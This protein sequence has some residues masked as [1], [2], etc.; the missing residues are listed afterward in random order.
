MRRK[1]WS[2]SDRGPIAGD[3]LREAARVTPR[4]GSIRARAVTSLTSIERFFVPDQL[5]PDGTVDER[6]VRRQQ[7]RVVGVVAV[8]SFVVFVPSMPVVGVPA[9]LWPSF[10]AGVVATG[11]IIAGSLLVVPAGT[12]AGLLAAAACAVALFGF[13]RLIG[14]YYHEL[15]LL[16]AFV[17]A[18]HVMVKGWGA[19]L[20]MAL[21]GAFLVPLMG[22]ASHVSNLTDNVYAFMYLLA[23]AATL[24]VHKRLQDRGT[25]AVG[26]SAARY[27]ELVERVPAIV[28]EADFALP[29]LWRYVSPRAEALLGFPAEAWT[30]AP[31][32][33]WNRVH[34]DDRNLLMAEGSESWQPAGQLST[35][36]YR[37]IGRDG[38]VRWVRDEATVVPSRDGLAAYRSGLLIDITEQKDLEA[39]LRQAQRMEAVGQLAGGIAHDF[40]NVL[41]A[42]KGYGELVR[43]DFAPDARG[44][45][46]LEEMLKAADR[47]ADL[48]RQLLAFSRKQILQPKV[49][50]PATVIEEIAPM[51]RRLIGEHIELVTQHMVRDAS[52]LVDQSQ[53]EQV[54][55]NLSVNA[56]DAMPDGGRLE[57]RTDVVVRNSDSV[58][59]GG[60][61]TPGS[62]LRIRVV[63]SGHGMDPATRARI[64]E[65]FFTTKDVGR[66]TGMGLATVYGIVR[67]SGGHIACMSEPG[68]GATFE[69]DLPLV[70]PSAPYPAPDL[71]M[72][73]PLGRETILL[74]EDDSAV[75]S[76]ARRVLASLGYTVFEASSGAEAMEL[77]EASEARLDLLVTDVRM[78]Q[79]QGPDLA[80]RLRAVRPGLAV[81]LMSGFPGDQHMGAPGTTVEIPLLPKP[82]DAETLGRAVRSALDAPH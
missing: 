20:V 33:W 52:V 36:E 37:M 11:F 70:D 15:P 57:I 17:V 82:F 50:R 80:R 44:R 72:P 18:G 8:A 81:L 45:E 67:Q 10:V 58:E 14:D 21:C 78:P 69:L 73:P 42:I 30:N 49:I 65:P 74:V 1:G 6:A 62:S 22:A 46:D 71:E 9:H 24:W 40:N 23:I 2:V 27:R 68:H 29:G 31:G 63:D 59:A 64:F 39:R 47:A 19:A 66:G 38:G 3:G 60:A 55:V 32:F 41:T 28:Y 43:A 25:V 61:A 48:T 34:P 13:D 77:A 12:K 35:V 26:S 76:F 7:R 79:M 56:R 51:L 4:R 54:I 5:R 16:F 53:F 75:R